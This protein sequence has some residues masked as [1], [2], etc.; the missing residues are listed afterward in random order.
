MNRARHTR[1][2]QWPTFIGKRCN[3]NGSNLNEKTQT[4]LVF[5][6]TSRV[7]VALFPQ[8]LDMSMIIPHSQDSIRLNPNKLKRVTLSAI[9]IILALFVL[10]CE[11]NES[12]VVRNEANGNL[13][14]AAIDEHHR[15]NGSFPHR[16]ED[17]VPRFLPEIPRAE[18]ATWEIT[19]SMDGSVLYLAF[20]G[21]GDRDP[22]GFWNSK[23]RGW[24]SDTK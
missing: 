17:L 22:D 8:T 13:I 14:V 12:I 18:Y 19:F 20:D 3:R 5:E 9:T 16:L 11:D 10:G 4:Q 1:S 7:P 15:V 2:Q 24:I 21:G 23:D 6:R